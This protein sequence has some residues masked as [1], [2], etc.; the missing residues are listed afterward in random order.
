MVLK[1]LMTEETMKKI[2]RFNNGREVWL[3][4]HKIYV[5][6][7]DNQLYNF[8]LQYFQCKW[9]VNGSMAVHLS[10]LKNLWSKLNLGLQ[11]K[12]EVQLPQIQL[13]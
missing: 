6:T 11:R 8:S 13:M 4:L 12:Q 1:N 10:N 2:M 7:S 3:E 5:A 9:T